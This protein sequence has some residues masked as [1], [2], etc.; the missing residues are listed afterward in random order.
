MK[1]STLPTSRAEERIVSN[2]P[3]V[4]VENGDI[5]AVEDTKVETVE[6]C[7]EIDT[8]VDS[9]IVGKLKAKA[10]ARSAMRGGNEAS[11]ELLHRQL[12]TEI[13]ARFRE[14]EG[15]ANFRRA[16]IPPRFFGCDR[17]GEF[18]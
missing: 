12:M 1:S 3:F 4:P 7:V 8:K 16:G 10:I 5:P 2:V 17:E 15:R 13:L 18:V 6:N 14:T 11:R 9:E